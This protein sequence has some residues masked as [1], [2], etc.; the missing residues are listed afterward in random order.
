M[1]NINTPLSSAFAGAV[2][3]IIIYYINNK[4]SKKTIENN[5]YIKLFILVFVI[6]YVIMNLNK[7]NILKH[8]GGGNIHTGNPNF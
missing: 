8:N 1:L 5:T 3:S 6:I 7:G 4:L 2:A